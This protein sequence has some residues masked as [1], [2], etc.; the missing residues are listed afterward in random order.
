MVSSHADGHPVT[1]FYMNAG[2]MPSAAYVQ[3]WDT[4]R[5]GGAKV[6]PSYGDTDDGLFKIQQA[7]AGRAWLILLATS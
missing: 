5:E 3:E 2:G 6:V 1:L 7:L 4:W